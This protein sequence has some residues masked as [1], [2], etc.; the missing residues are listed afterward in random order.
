M[1][2]NKQPLIELSTGKKGV[3]QEI[4]GGHG[5]A[6]RAA[7]LGFT[8]GAEVQMLQNYGRGPLMVG[9]RGTRLALGRGE[10]RHIQVETA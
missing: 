1:N 2:K 10:A 8:I 5:F 3:V 4:R 6:M 9:V 7:A